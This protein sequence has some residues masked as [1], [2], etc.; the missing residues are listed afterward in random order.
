MLINLLTVDWFI[1]INIMQ[2][3]HV[4]FRAILDLLTDRSI[5]TKTFPSL[6]SLTTNSQ[7]YR[8]EPIKE[9]CCHRSVLIL[10]IPQLWKGEWVTGQLA[11]GCGCGLTGG[12]LAYRTHR[13]LSALGPAC[14]QPPNH[15]HL[16]LS[17]PSR[18]TSRYH[19]DA[20]WPFNDGI[21][22]DPHVRLPQC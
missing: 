2:Y 12:W 3:R 6:P 16:T 7:C 1:W 5:H 11:C 14:L 15:D 13:A 21:V 9:V 17:N 19:Y 10:Y 18:H 20:S 8:T 4:L 22:A